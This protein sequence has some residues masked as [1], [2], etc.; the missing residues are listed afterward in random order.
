[1]PVNMAARHS[2]LLFPVFHSIPYGLRLLPNADV[3]DN[4]KNGRE[5]AGTA[6]VGDFGILSAHV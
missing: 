5:S 3:F 6:D 4:A 2:D 1:M